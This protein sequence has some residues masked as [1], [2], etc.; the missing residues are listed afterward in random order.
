MDLSALRRAYLSEQ[1]CGEVGVEGV[2]GAPA[3]QEAGPPALSPAKLAS[4]FARS[5][6][7]IAANPRLDSL[8]N[9]FPSVTAEP[10][11]SGGRPD[12]DMALDKL[13]RCIVYSPSQGKTATIDSYT[14]NPNELTRN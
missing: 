1:V 13:F 4:N 10:P 5:A 3:E 9:L 2:D 14:R 11:A 8:L 6:A 12:L 7:R